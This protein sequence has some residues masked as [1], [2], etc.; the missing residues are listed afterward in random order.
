MIE[1]HGI[2]VKALVQNTLGEYLLI[3]R[4]DENVHGPGKWEIPGGRIDPGE[5]PYDGLHREVHEE[6]GLSIAV[7]RPLA[8]SHFMRD[9]D[10]VIVMIVFLAILE[11][12]TDV[13]LSSEHTDFEWLGHDEAMEKITPEMHHVF[14]YL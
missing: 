2:A 5:D 12:G 3:K 10:Q 13:V 7:G 9:D 4:N 6:V 14:D 8:V 11:E 1:N